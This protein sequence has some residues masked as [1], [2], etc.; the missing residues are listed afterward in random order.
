MHPDE[1]PLVPP[2]ESQR[3]GPHG[4]PTGQ[5]YIWLQPDEEQATADCGC[6]LV[7]NHNGSGDPAVFLCDRHE[8]LLVD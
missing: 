1:R 5:P 4:R 2:S 3:P 7:R 8:A 6:R